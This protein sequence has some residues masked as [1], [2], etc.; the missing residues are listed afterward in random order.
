MSRHPDHLTVFYPFPAVPRIPCSQPVNHGTAP[1]VGYD[2]EQAYQPPVVQP[3]ADLIQT[4]VAMPVTTEGRADEDLLQVYYG[5][6]MPVQPQPPFGHPFIT[7]LDQDDV[8]P[9]LAVP[10]GHLKQ[11]VWCSDGFHDRQ[12]CSSTACAPRSI[13]SAARVFSRQRR[14]RSLLTRAAARPC[15]PMSVQ[16]SA[17]K[18]H[19]QHLGSGK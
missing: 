4:P 19:R 12:V 14:M 15:D 13:L 6:V 5:L 18:P 11:P 2:V 16:A 7:M 17:S 1:V 8:L 3:P 9:A 10:P